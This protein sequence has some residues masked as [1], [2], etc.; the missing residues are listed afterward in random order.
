MLDSDLA[1]LYQVETRVLNQAVKRNISRFPEHYYF[2]LTE[3]ELMASK[4]HFVILNKKRGS[5]TKYLPHVF[6]EQ[7]V[8]IKNAGKKAFEN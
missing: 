6:T 2:K 3:E 7:G 4:S 5:N 8:A 1:H